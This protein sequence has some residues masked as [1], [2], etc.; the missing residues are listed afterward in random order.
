D[1]QASANATMR[2][3]LQGL[4]LTQTVTTV[5]DATADAIRK[6]QSDL[7]PSLGVANPATGWTPAWSLSPKE[8]LAVADFLI[9]SSITTVARR[10]G[11]N[12]SWTEN[13]PYEPLVG[14]T[15]T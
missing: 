4:N 14:N 12:W 7:G 5:P 11:V 1:Q 13:W 9:Y 15:P 10:P 3:Q 2:Q 8:K 6:I